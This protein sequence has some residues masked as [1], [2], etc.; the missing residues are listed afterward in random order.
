MSDI[1]NFLALIVIGLLGVCMWVG[2]RHFDTI[3][4]KKIGDAFNAVK[5]DATESINKT[6]ISELKNQLEAKLKP[7][8][9]QMQR[10][11]DQLQESIKNQSIQRAKSEG[12]FAEQI[13]SL[14]NATFGMQEDAQNLTKALK[15]D[16]QQQGA[17]GEQVL[18]SALDA[19]GLKENISYFLQPTYKDRK[20][21]NLRPDAVILFPPDRN[22]VIDS[23]VSLT[24]YERF[25]SAE[26]L[27]EKESHLKEHI[28]SIKKHIKIL[29][30]KNYND[31]E[32]LNAPDYLFIFVPIDSALSVALTKSLEL[33]TLANEH[34][35]AF[36]TPINL[37]AILRVVENLWRLDSQ[38]KHAEDIANRAGLLFD[39]FSN[40]NKDLSDVGR[41]IDKVQESYNS[42]INK[43][44]EGDGNLFTHV[45]KLK[46]LG[47]KTQKELSKPK[48]IFNE[49]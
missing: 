46:D 31:L 13:D 48:K 28:N 39:K 2:Y 24:A 14:R 40:L 30:S 5:D 6:H 7:F 45:N 29:S 23:K 35:I 37:I 41:H 34:K 22:I 38:N 1:I 20:G 15:G 47:A 42:A 17:W 44:S 3:L 9:D 12:K 49:D 26:D 18:E 43:L 16:V 10:E 25:V 27:E 11:I 8:G 32:D 19:A 21:N 4:N 36:V 33:Q